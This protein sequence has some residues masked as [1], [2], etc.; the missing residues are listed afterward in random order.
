MGP[1]G[2]R[3][4]L[5]VYGFTRDEVEIT[6]EDNQLIVRGLQ[7]ESADKTF[8]H[9][10]IA[11]RQFQRAFVL[12]DGIEARGA[13]LESGLLSIE[14]AHPKPKSVTRRIDIRNGSATTA[15]RADGDRQGPERQKSFTL[16]RSTALP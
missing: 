9:R 1:G 5:A 15:G 13:E 12:A 14:L 3:I 6:I 11:A 2:L 16:C 10:G 8:L 7:T 4:V